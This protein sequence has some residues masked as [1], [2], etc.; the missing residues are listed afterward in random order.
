MTD[1]MDDFEKQ[2]PEQETNPAPEPFHLNE[3][4]FDEAYE[5][6][7]RLVSLNLAEVDVNMFSAIN[8]DLVNDGCGLYR[9]RLILPYEH[10]SRH[11]N[12]LVD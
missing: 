1:K 2:L 12:E 5:R 3:I 10:L 8:N 4:D 7:Q 6:C 11:Q 9:G